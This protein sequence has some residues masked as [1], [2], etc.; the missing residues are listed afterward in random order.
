MSLAPRKPTGARVS[1]SHAARR[2]LYKF[3]LPTKHTDRNSSTHHCI[4][5]PQNTDSERVKHPTED[6]STPARWSSVA[7]GK[8]DKGGWLDQSTPPPP[9]G[10]TSQRYFLCQKPWLYHPQG[11]KVSLGLR[12]LLWL[13]RHLPSCKL[14]LTPSTVLTKKYTGSCLLILCWFVRQFSLWYTELYTT[15]AWN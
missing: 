5:L 11:N 2:P 10:G 8:G 4:T 15:L 6:E 9:M 12:C 13:H 3:L 1:F 14:S 7:S